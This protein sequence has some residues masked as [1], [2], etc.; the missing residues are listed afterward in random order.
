M[1]NGNIQAMPVS[2]I[3]SFVAE[4]ADHFTMDIDGEGTFDIPKSEIV[5]REDGSKHDC[6]VTVTLAWAKKRGLLHKCSLCK[7]PTGN[8]NHCPACDGYICDKC[9]DPVDFRKLPVEHRVADHAT[10]LKAA[11]KRN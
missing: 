6:F 1:K 7:E 3:G 10:L 9:D 5:N 2:L 8:A 4:H 11:L